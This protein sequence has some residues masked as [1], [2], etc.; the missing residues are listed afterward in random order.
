MVPTEN[1]DCTAI[2]LDGK[3]PCEVACS[4]VAQG[5]EPLF[6]T[7]EHVIY[8]RTKPRPTT[9]IGRILVYDGA[10]D[11]PNPRA[12]AASTTSVFVDRTT[13]PP[14]LELRAGSCIFECNGSSPLAAR[15]SGLAKSDAQCRAACPPSRRYRYDGRRLRALR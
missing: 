13:S 2:D 3:E 6:R 5:P 1:D 7:R 12:A 15:R 8:F 11:A 4:R 14:T 10:L 9:E